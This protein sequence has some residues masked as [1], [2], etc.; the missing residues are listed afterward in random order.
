MAAEYDVAETAAV[1][2]MSELA[3]QVKR[4][5]AENARL[6]EEVQHIHSNQQQNETRQDEQAMGLVKDIAASL[7]NQNTTT[8]RSFVNKAGR[9]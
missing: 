8:L 4:L 3:M 6:R 7:E 2:A 9:Y 1:S 5:I